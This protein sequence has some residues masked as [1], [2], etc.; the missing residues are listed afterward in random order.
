MTESP[1]KLEYPHGVGLMEPF[2]LIQGDK[3][4]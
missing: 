4:A 1:A 2:G 3:P